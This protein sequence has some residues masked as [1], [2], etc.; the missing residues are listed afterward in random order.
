MFMHGGLLHIG[1]NMV[2]LWVFGDNIGDTLGHI[3]Y[4]IFYL[5]AGLAAAGAQIMVDTQSQ[6]PMV[7]AS[8]A[9]AGVPGAYLVLHSNGGSG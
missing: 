4:L 5:I 8:G 1:A 6:V 7:G 3:P 9:I 2:Y